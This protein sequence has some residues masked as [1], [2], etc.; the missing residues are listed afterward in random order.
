MVAAATRPPDPRRRALL[1]GRLHAPA[2]LRPPW[3][4]DES[5]FAD[6]C[7]ACGACVA[8]CPERVLVLGEGRL[9]VFDP[10]QGE[11]TFC[12]DCVSACEAGAFR[13]VAGPAWTLQ[14]TVADDCLTLHGIVCSSCR[15]ACGESA[16]RFPVTSRV[17]A[18]VVAADRCTGC[19][20][21]VA[22][23]PAAAI[24]LRP[25]HEERSHV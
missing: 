19:G 10:G 11:C 7:T 24:S 15:D 21:C 18:P 3:S 25:A 2:V 13:P 17:P 4:L 12:T 23:C 5:A 22:G 16:I 8:A 6:A 1:R 14:A 20:A 9:P